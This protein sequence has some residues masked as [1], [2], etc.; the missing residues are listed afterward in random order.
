MTYSPRLVPRPP[1]KQLRGDCVGRLSRALAL[2]SLAIWGIGEAQA[3]LLNWDA[4]GNP[5]NGLGGSGTWNTIA[6]TF[7]EDGIAPD[8]IWDNLAGNTAV[9]SGTSGTVTLGGPISA[10]GLIFGV[11]GYVISGNTLTLAGGLEVTNPGENATINSVLAGTTG[12]TKSGN[13]LLTLGGTNTFTGAISLTAG[14]LSFSNDNRLGNAANDVILGGGELVYTGSSDWNPGSGRVIQVTAAAAIK[15]ES[16]TRRI[17]LDDAGQLAGIG[18]LSKRG[19]GILQI[20]G[21]NSGFT[22]NVNIQEGV[23]EAGALGQPTSLGTGAGQTLTITGGELA[24]NRSSLAHTVVVGAPGVVLSPSAGNVA[25]WDSTLAGPIQAGANAFTVGLR[26]HNSTNNARSL[27]ITG[28]LTGSAPID[29]TGPLSGVVPG[30]LWLDNNNAGFSGGLTIGNRTAVRFNG[31]ASRV[32]AYT[33]ESGGT[34]GFNF[35]NATGAA[36]V[37]APG[38]EVTYFNLGAGAGAAVYGHNYAQEL[39]V[40]TPGR[41]TLPLT[42]QAVN[43]PPS[44][45]GTFPVVPVQGLGTGG[46]QNGALW[47]GLIQIGTAGEYTFNLPSDD[48]SLLFIDGRLVVNNDFTHPVPSVQNTNGHI[49]SIALTPGYHSIQVKF[50]QAAGTASAILNYS[51]PDTGGASVLAGSQPNVLFKG[52]MP[53][54]DIGPLSM[55]VGTGTVEITVDS[56]TN[57]LTIP[58]GGVFQLDSP[59]ISTLSVTGLAP[60]AGNVT[61]AARS[62]RLN[63]DAALTET[64]PSAVTFAGPYITSLTQPGSYTGI[65]TV[66]GGQLRLDAAA[67]NSVPADLSINASNT[68]P[69]SNVVL[70]RPDQIANGATVSIESGTLDLLGNSDTIGTLILNGRGARLIGSGVLTAGT[71]DLRAGEVA[72]PLAHGGGLSHTTAGTLILSGNNTYAGLTSITSGTVVAASP[73][74]L[75][76]VG[77]GNETTVG[78]GG[79]LRL[80]GGISTSESLTVAGRLVSFGGANAISS[81]PSFADGAHITAAAGTFTMPAGISLDGSTASVTL[82][83]AGELIVPG[84]I[85]LAQLTKN[86]TGLLTFEQTLTALPSNLVVNSGILGFKGVQN[87]GAVTVPAGIGYQFYNDPG[88]GTTI[89]VPAG[90]FVIAGYPVD[91]GLLSRLGP[92]SDGTLLLSTDTSATL[93]LTGHGVSIGAAGARTAKLSGGLIL[94]PGVLHIGGG[95]GTVEIVS[96]IPSSEIALTGRAYFSSVA[97]A[98][99]TTTVDAGGRLVFANSTQLGAPGSALTLSNGGVLE[100]AHTSG[101]ATALFNQLG[102]PAAPF[103]ARTVTLTGSGGTI[104]I[105][106]QAGGANAMVFTGANTLS[107]DSGTTLKKTG[108]GQLIFAD[109]QSFTGHLVIAASGDRVELRGR[110]ALPAVASVTVGQAGNLV[111]DNANGL[112]SR[113]WLSKDGERLSDD[114]PITLNGGKL[115]HRV[116]ATSSIASVEKVGALAIGPGQAELRVE[117]TN[118]GGGLFP[119]SINRLA[120][121][122]ILNITTSNGTLGA[123]GTAPSVQT[124]TVNGLTPSALLAGGWLTL[125]GT[126]F[127][128]YG[129][130]GFV[131]AAYADQGN[132]AFSPDAGFISNLTGSGTATLNAGNMAM[133]ALRFSATG[134]QTLQFNSETQQLNLVSGGLLSDNQNVARTIGGAADFGR[135]TAGSIS[136]ATP[137]SLFLFANQNTLTVNARVIDNPAN[138]AAT[139]QVVKGLD[140]TVQLNSTANAY[141]GGTAVYRGTLIANGPGTLGTGSVRVEGFSVIDLRSSNTVSGSAIPGSLPVFTALD[142]AE[143]FLNNAVAYTGSN[144]RFSVGA[145]STLTANANSYTQGLAA[146]TRVTAFTGGGQVVLAPDAIV[147]AQNMVAQPGL[148][149]VAI[150]NLGTAADLYF[151]PVAAS[152][153]NDSASLTIGSGTPWKGLSSSRSGA[154]WNSGTL[155]A[156]GDFF[157]QGLARDSGMATLTL[158]GS[159]STGTYGIVN[160]SGSPIQAFVT[161]QVALDEDTGV[162]MPGNLTFVVTNGGLL[163]PNRSRSFGDS[164]IRPGSGIASVL[165]QAGGTLDPGNFVP[166]GGQANQGAGTPGSPALPYPLESPLNGAVTIEG[167]GRLLLNDTS[168]LGSSNGVIAMKSNAVL[169]LGNTNALLGSHG[170]YVNA[171]R[172]SYEPRVIIRNTA[173]SVN[174]LQQLLAEAPQPV[175]EVFTTNQSLTNQTNPFIIPGLGNPSAAPEN[176]TLGAGVILT[177]DAN[178]RQVTEGRGKIILTS[179]VTLAAANQSYLSLQEGLEIQDGATINIGTP[180]IIDGMARLGGIHFVTPNGTILPTSG[181]FTLNMAE[182]TQITLLGQNSWPDHRGIHLPNAVTLPD[183]NSPDPD[184]KFGPIQPGNGHSLLLNVDNFTEVIGPLTGNGAVMSNVGSGRLGVGWAASADFSFGGAFRE[185]NLRTVLGD[186]TRQPTLEKFGATKM[187]LTGASDSLGDLRVWQGELS[188]ALSGSSKFAFVRPGKGATL[189]LDNTD[190]AANDRLGGKTVVGHGGTLRLVGNATTPVRETVAQLNNSGNPNGGITYLNVEAGGA[191]TIF[192]ATTLQAFEASGLHQ[193]TWVYRSPAAANRPGTYNPD[194]VYTP[195]PANLLTGLFNAVNPN[196][197]SNYNYGATTS[198]ITAALGTPV[199][200]VR[201]DYLADASLTGIGT[202]FVTQDTVGAGLNGIRLLDASEYSGTFSQGASTSLNVKLSGSIAMTGDTRFAT[203]TMAPGTTLDIAGSMPASTAP[204]RLF[205]HTGGIYLQGGTGSTIN[206]SGNNVLQSVSTSGVWLHGPGDLALNATVVSDFNIVKSGGGTVNF[207]TGAARLWRGMMVLDS[208]TINLG[209]NNSF[210]VTRGLV[211]NSSPASTGQSLGLNGG[212]LN[213]NG[214]SQLIGT[215]TNA[216]FAGFGD[217][218][219]G[220]LHSATPAVVSVGLGGGRFTGQITGAISL[221]KFGNN[222]LILANNAPYTGMTTVRGG[223]LVLRDEA[224]IANTSQVDIAYGTLRLDSGALAKYNDRVNPSAVINSRGGTVQLDGRVGEVVTQAFSTF[225]I[226]E[227]RNDFNALAGA[228]GATIYL[229]GDFTRAAGSRATVN[230]NQNFGFVGAAGNDTTAIRYMLGTLN[231]APVALTNNLVAPWMTV[232]GDHFATYSPTNG[233]GA[234]GNTVDGFANYDSTDLSTATALQNVN[235][236]SSRTIATS[237]VVNALRL[238]PTAAQDITLNAGVTLTIGSGGILS[239]GTQ[240]VDIGRDVGSL[241]QGA[242]TSGGPDLYVWVNQGATVL[243]TVVTGA[244][245]LV[246]SGPNT[247]ELR[248]NNT[249]TGVTEVHA[250]SLTLNTLGANGSTVVSIPGDLVIRNATVTESQPN[251]IANS[252]NVTLSSGAVLNL[253]DVAGINETIA[254]LT[255]V[256]DGG[257]SLFLNP[258]VTR[259]NARASSLTITAANAVTASSTN[260][261][262]TPTLGANIGLVHFAGTAGAPQFLS[263]SGSY[264]GANPSVVA[265]GLVINAGIGNVPAGVAG[266]GLVKTGNGQLILA[267]GIASTF[268]NPAVPT[269]VFNIQQGV[270]RVDEP[271]KLGGINAI[272]TVQSGAALLLATGSA[273]GREL[274]AGIRLNTGAT[275]GLTDPGTNAGGILGV[276]T[277]DEA[278]QTTLNVAGDATIALADYFIS[279]TRPLDMAVRGKLTGSGALNLTGA[280][281]LSGLGGGGTLTLGNPIPAGSPGANDYD[282]TITVGTNAILQNLATILGAN[283][284]ASGSALGDAT[285][286]LAGGRLR[287]RDDGSS[288]ADTS[289]TLVPYGNHVT[290]LADSFLDA[291][292]QAS[293]T[294]SNNTIEMGVL[295]VG[296]GARALTVDSANNYRVSFSALDGPGHFVKSGNGALVFNAISGT[297]GGSVSVAGPRGLSV[298]PSSNLVLP[299]FTTLNQFTVDGAHSVPGSGV[300]SIAGTLTVGNNAGQVTNGYRGVTSGAVTGAISVSGTSSITADVVRNQGTIGATF[301]SG[302]VAASGSI[303]GTGLFVAD[304]STLSLSGLVADDGPTATV[305]KVAGSGV[306]A[307]TGPAAT[308]T[309]GTEVQSGTLR[310]APAGPAVNPLGLAPIRTL[311]YGTTAGTSSTGGTLQFAGDDILHTGGISNQGTVRIS[312]GT[313]TIQGTVAGTAPSYVTGLLEGRITDSQDLTATRPQS[314]GNF[315][316]RT[317]PRMAQMSVVTSDPITG[318][319]SNETWVYTG[320][321]YDADG[322]FSFAENLDDMALLVI[323]GVPVIANGLFDQVSSSAF[324]VGQTGDSGYQSGANTSIGGIVATPTIDFGPGNSGWHSFELRIRNGSGAA[325]ARENTGFFRNFGLGYREDGATALDGSLYTRPIADPTADPNLPADYQR[326]LFRTPIG[327]KG[328]VQVDDGAT[329]NVGAFTMTN[330]I[331]LNSSGN[332]ATLNLLNAGSHDAVSIQ[333]HDSDLQ[334][335]NLPVGFLSIPTGS[336]VT[337]TN[338]TIDTGLLTKSGGGTV[339]IGGDGSTQAIEGELLIDEG[340]VTFAGAGSG[341]GNGIVTLNNGVFE[342]TGSLT[343]SV[344]VNNGRLTGKSAS[345]TTGL[346][347]GPV[348]LTGGTIEPGEA[349]PGLLQFGGISFLGG[350][351]AATLNG[352]VEGSGYDQLA[353]TG[354]VIFGAPTPLSISLGFNPVDGVDRFTLISNDGVDPVTGL[355][356]FSFGGMALSENDRF[357]VIG[358]FTQTFAISY[359]GGDGNDVV[360]S[361]VVPEPSAALLLL[362]GCALVGARRRRSHDR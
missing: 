69:V 286:Q 144:D 163:Q 308:H 263:V 52:T 162:L 347:S 183:T 192:T 221:D 324:T 179:G 206:A 35:L 290:L 6:A 68:A 36:A 40:S 145:G 334:D 337:A 223:S 200:A 45:S 77:A 130:N 147:R 338:L 235:D 157:L 297:F 60:L 93:N 186:F 278:A 123:G 287:L 121:G 172:F 58:A 185:T 135:I 11:S 156:N 355:G 219:G 203:L 47:K 125:N 119:A 25:N 322:R 207:G 17:I 170:G 205:L 264:P 323:D 91:G 316:I 228:S 233:I 166:V 65:T 289:N 252:A 33:L 37:G 39:L 315:G 333:L 255:L 149:G 158:G 5:A 271:N 319:S 356:F 243:N 59:T 216:N 99:L 74:A 201:P 153:L 227:G 41:F 131:Q 302:S 53:A 42:E 129:A 83:G 46:L 232:A 229:F 62:G 54:S 29:V 310:V 359:S 352:I 325:G 276:A 226:L 150:Q 107:G 199:V 140:G 79:T 2:A 56:T 23:L 84:S 313:T 241:P 261:S 210:F 318:W 293:T 240:T 114:A 26:D 281:H 110:G 354:E 351:L 184:I 175:L 171:G 248:G 13:G 94:D 57:S 168:G 98:A 95:S 63:L 67:G 234:L 151:S 268:G 250:G 343:G 253:R 350:E 122:G 256:S 108:L 132:S 311:G 20:S 254:S 284:R 134:S 86:G 24:V 328:N 285:I 18:T 27:R 222:E 103:S 61:I 300:L 73:S 31:L 274:T 165:V 173:G 117:T 116:R 70:A 198:T 194:G 224:R 8:T 106:A 321:F 294:A 124:G 164:T 269:D 304:G 309:G 303:R 346:V 336:T 80:V 154:A 307:L 167:G 292:R 339:T 212:T 251:Q 105:P 204:S 288:T 353:I 78:A 14:A 126:H 296:A 34:V 137:Q 115:T 244:I 113:Q 295:T 139:V 361:A 312:G 259:G 138:A 282:G 96:S 330:G 16:S 305:L 128:A 332:A 357:T 273:A 279:E 262:Q 245:N 191:E 32:S 225:N 75:G 181:S 242:I 260:A 348:T 21:S 82:D 112:G 1:R 174:R 92:G 189:T 196:F 280:S 50:G 217:A 257:G 246:K 326:A 30:V 197:Y 238:A 38:L 97:N 161:G 177:G 340:K 214:N 341:S 71:Y 358:P 49:G 15:V 169:E 43:L 265:T 127:L 76:A 220:T 329:L 190:T 283:T 344:S 159:S 182:G 335:I 345:P 360:L 187:T 193:T 160:G 64:A 301:G 230:F 218:A 133:N 208:G 3:A 277:L 249:H 152:G 111:L 342:V 90:S 327:G 202:G 87:L 231:G 239:N 178:D 89:T 100:S 362:G 101:T 51:G 275:L 298:A 320:E 148:W 211:T 102:N 81:T 317:E 72:A 88:P 19:S 120:S 267:G 143:I 306:V 314:P 66:T 109:V 215:L 331:I 9:F 236:G 155:I 22:G 299:T 195:N 247:L 4:D 10:A 176:L 12:L 272:T 44:A 55:P 142:G 349:S 118:L 209:A 104:D 213:L 270:V 266:G 146:L 258:I 85:N 7:D 136:A 237:K 291:G 188:I 180:Q 48:G 28:A 141:S